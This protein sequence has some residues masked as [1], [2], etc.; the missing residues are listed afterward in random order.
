MQ[1]GGAAVA[2]LDDR[3][4][5]RAAQMLSVPCTGTLGILLKAKE[6]S[7]MKSIKPALRDLER[8]GF[9]LDPDTHAAVCE[10]AGE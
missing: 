10:I 3:M 5:R 9:R 6:Q 2:V 4:A 8:C 7:L 1:M